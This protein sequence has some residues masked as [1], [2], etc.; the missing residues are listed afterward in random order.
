MSGI[1][2]SVYLVT[3]P[4]LKTPG[5]EVCE[6]VD[7]ACSA[8]VSAVQYRDKDCPLEQYILTARKLKCIT[9]RHGVPL[10][11]NDHVTAVRSVGADGIH[12][13]QDDMSA[14]QV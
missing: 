13:G 10:I 5:L 4:V 2:L 6:I 11:L 1:N 8:G 3:D 14:A 12:V 7:R 9:S